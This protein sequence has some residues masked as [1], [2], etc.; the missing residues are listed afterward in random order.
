MVE[1]LGFPGA[2]VVRSSTEL[3]WDLMLPFAAWSSA[4]ALTAGVCVGTTD[5]LL[6]R[7]IARVLPVT[8]KA[9]MWGTWQHF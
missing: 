9:V 8:G 1:A 5:T 2:T 4:R 3:P 6:R 7:H